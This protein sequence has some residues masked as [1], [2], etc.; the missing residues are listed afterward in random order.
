VQ[1]AAKGI[2]CNSVMPGYIATPRITDRLRKSNPNDYD[3]KIKT[4]NERAER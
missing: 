4:P 1:Y 3:D 2:R